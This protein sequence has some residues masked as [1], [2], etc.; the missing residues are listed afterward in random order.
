MSNMPRRGN[1][2][3][4][5]ELRQVDLGQEAEIA[6]KTTVTTMNDADDDRD[7]RRGQQDRADQAARCAPARRLPRERSA[8]RRPG[9]RRSSLVLRLAII[10]RS[11]RTVGGRRDRPGLRAGP[12]GLGGG[13]AA[14]G[15]RPRR[16]AV[17][18][19]SSAGRLTYGTVS[20][21]VEIVPSAR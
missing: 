6:S 10:G 14:T 4:R 7:E 21:T 17:A 19:S 12:A 3:S 8:R 20:R 5:D 9:W 16:S 15:G 18:S 13:G 11:S 2:P 1:Q